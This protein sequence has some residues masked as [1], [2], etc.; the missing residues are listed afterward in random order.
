MTEAIFGN[1]LEIGV[2]TL[3][4]GLL[5]N[6]EEQGFVTSTGAQQRGAISIMW[7]LL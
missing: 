7:F 2:F 4:Y 3:D 1:G 5:N 6:C